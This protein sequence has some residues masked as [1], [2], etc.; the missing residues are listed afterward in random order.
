MP[1]W[2]PAGTLIDAWPSRRGHFYLRAECG[3]DKVDRDFAK[4]VVTVALENLMRFNVQH[5][6]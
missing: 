4:E 3:L 6:V 5:D 1:G 2:V